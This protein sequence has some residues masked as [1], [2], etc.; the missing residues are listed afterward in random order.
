MTLLDRRTCTAEPRGQHPSTS[1]GRLTVTGS[2]L[3]PGNTVGSAQPWEEVAPE[4]SR[5]LNLQLVSGHHR[6]RHVLSPFRA[7]SLALSG[8]ARPT[9]VPLWSCPQNGRQGH[10]QLLATRGACN[11]RRARPLGKRQAGSRGADRC[12][13]PATPLLTCA[14]LP[15]LST[16]GLKA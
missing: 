8:P 2:A 6:R 16:E 7:F 4:P 12:C 15:A 13:D 1:P 3:G 5:E 14:H 10:E 11:F 9:V